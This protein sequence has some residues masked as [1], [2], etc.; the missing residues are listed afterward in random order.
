M[1]KAIEKLKAGFCTVV[2]SALD[3]AR[4]N[5]PEDPLPPTKTGAVAD[6]DME[7]NKF[8]RGGHQTSVWKEYTYTYI[9]THTHT[10]TYTHIY[11]YRRS[12]VTLLLHIPCVF[13]IW[14]HL[15]P[16]TNT[17]THTN[18][19]IPEHTH[20]TIYLHSTAHPTPHTHTHTHTH[21]MSVRNKTCVISIPF[22]QPHK[23]FTS[24]YQVSPLAHKV[25]KTVP[26]YEPAVT[27]CVCRICI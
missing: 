20:S 26:F 27:M 25:F 22:T 13:N 16:T 6:D 8:V 19:A 14:H 11:I 5:L 21:T 23:T 15:H 10:H 18:Q 9:Y 3:K 1:A 17:L 4:P 24:L 7:L 12:P 2:I